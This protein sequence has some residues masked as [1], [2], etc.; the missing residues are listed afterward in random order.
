MPLTKRAVFSHLP[1]PLLCWLHWLLLR[2]PPPG[3]SS[4]LLAS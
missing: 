1:F 4:Y 3:A 2:A